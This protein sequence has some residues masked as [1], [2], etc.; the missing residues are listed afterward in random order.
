MKRI[1]VVDD[2]KFIR[3]GI[4]RM[5]ET[6][7]P[8]KYEVVL[9]RNG[10]EAKEI[11]G[12]QWC[13]MVLTDISMP[14]GDGIDLIHYLAHMEI[15]PLIVI[16]SGYDRFSYAVEGMRNGVAD[17]LLK[18][19]SQEDIT[20]ILDKYDVS[21]IQQN[22]DVEHERELLSSEIARVILDKDLMSSS[23]QR[24]TLH[25][26]EWISS[27]IILI[28][29]LRIQSTM[30]RTYIE[31][32]LKAQCNDRYLM[33][34]PTGK[35]TYIIADGE[36][37]TLDEVLEYAAY[38]GKRICSMLENLPKECAIA[39]M[40]AKKAF[41]T[42]V[43]ICEAETS[44]VGSTSFDIALTELEYKFSIGNMEGF[45]TTFDKAWSLEKRKELDGQEFLG[46]LQVIVDFIDKYVP[47]ATQNYTSIK[48]KILDPYSMN[49]WEEF[50]NEFFGYVYI[51]MN[52]MKEKGRGGYT[53]P[54]REAIEFINENFRRDINLAL[55]ANQV[56]IN[57]S[58]LSRLFSEQVGETFVHYLKRRRI[59]A[60]KELLMTTD[61]PS[62][63]IGHEVGYQNDRQ[64][65]KV[66][67]EIVGITPNEYRK[68]HVKP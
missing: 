27:T 6:Q 8:G 2:E 38:A 23:V 53:Q 39:K 22:T 65:V 62:V 25:V 26:R 41:L 30:M 50:R 18:P 46:H 61:K 63:S 19:I 29:C 40:G 37:H 15:S 47:V 45:R 48:N 4:K 35:W 28:M 59:E 54:V 64:Y 34:P 60:A 21:H 32:K 56:G 66:F 31:G 11:I 55:V 12:K 24:I 57:Y 68:L 16:I 3:L 44:N 51:T 49:N 36:H 10:T 43:K 52:T 1:M 20:N 17:Y 13:D 5:I 33:T 58:V 42:E 67:K 9:A 14:F 7:R